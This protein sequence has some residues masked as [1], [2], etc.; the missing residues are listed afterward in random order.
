[1]AMFHEIVCTFFHRNPI[2]VTCNIH[3]CFNVPSF[4]LPRSVIQVFLY[5]TIFGNTL[6]RVDDHEYLGVSFSHD[7]C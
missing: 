5:Y 2:L 1:M 4:R 6:E 7:L 3:N